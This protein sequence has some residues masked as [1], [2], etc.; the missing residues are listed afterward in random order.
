[1]VLETHEEGGLLLRHPHM[2]ELSLSV[3]GLEIHV[4]RVGMD[5]AGDHPPLLVE[6][7]N[8]PIAE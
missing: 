4:Q 3:H 1:M 2:L 8:H 5:R 6:Q 7:F